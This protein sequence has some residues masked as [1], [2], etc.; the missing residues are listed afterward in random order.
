MSADPNITAF[1]CSS[2]QDLIDERE[3]VD[4]AVQASA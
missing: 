1:I 2:Y 4:G 3:Q